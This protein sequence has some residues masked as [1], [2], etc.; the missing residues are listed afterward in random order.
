MTIS[1]N[2]TEFAGKTVVDWENGSDISPDF[3]YRIALSYDKEEQGQVWT[4]NFATFLASP[5]SSQTTGLVVGTWQ[6]PYEEGAGRIV[7]AL[8]AARNR[9]PNLTALF[10][11]D[12]TYEECEISWIVQDDLTP[13]FEAYPQLE[14]FGAR[15]SSRLR[16]GPI[17]HA[18][19]KSL[20]IESGGLPV[21]I[22]QQV[23]ASQL[24]NL[25]HLELWLGIPDYGGDTTVADLAPLLAGELFPKLK[26]LGLRDSEVAD[27]IAKA[28]VNAPIL[29][30]IEVLDL[31]LGTLGDEGAEALLT[32][33]A[34]SKL[35]KLDI[36]HH[37]C[38]PEVVAQLE[39]LPITVDASDVQ[40]VD[41][42]DDEE[43]RYVAV[44][45]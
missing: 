29:E 44:S 39:E 45:E 17:Q 18:N 13:L 37:Y 26:Y 25:E 9:L 27:D 33:P 5:S 23:L 2:K 8:V 32:N 36:H 15:G 11:G 22:V 20:V 31:S 38:L 28:L 6:T 42:S 4:D 43:Y 19:L 3:C 10:I 41:H 14:Y 1:E 30:R 34:I 35:K 40:E 21:E 24:P 16:I 7:E 12:I